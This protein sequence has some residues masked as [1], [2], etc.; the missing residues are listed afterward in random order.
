M[1]FNHGEEMRSCLTTEG[2]ESTEKNK[3][4]QVRVFRG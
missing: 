4:K 1:S 3:Q 2:T